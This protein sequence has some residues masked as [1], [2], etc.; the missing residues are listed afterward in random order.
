[1]TKLNSK[2]IFICATEQ[3]GDNIGY[4][5]IKKLKKIF[6][7]CTFDGVGGN[8]M[9]LYLDHQYFSIKDFKSIGIFEIIFS[10]K[11]YINMISYL[12]KMIIAK[13]YDL[14]ITI[15]SPDFNYPLIKKI[16]NKKFKKNTLHIVA[17]TVWAWRKYRAKKFAKIFNE[18]FIL[19]DFERSYFLKYGLNATLIGHPIYYINKIKNDNKKSNIAFL[20]GS[21]THE[22]DTLM[23]FFQIAYQYL[24]KEKIALDIFIPTLPHLEKKIKEYTKHWKLRIIITSN[25]NEI[26]KFF[27]DSKF[28]LVCSGTASLE[29]AKRNIPQ[30]VIYKLNLFTE[31]ILKFI[32]KIR[33]ANIINIIE[34]K[35]IIPE[36]TNSNLTKNNFLSE[37]SQLISNSHLN[38]NQIENINKTLPKI[39]SERPPYDIAVEKISEYL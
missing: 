23:P 25:H 12:S 17:P 29:I 11:K 28:A 27:L 18:I 21:R 19:F 20:P 30:L 36:L 4:N 10:I 7:N 24:I 9:S 2:K 32:T 16:R 26:E 37:F 1:M 3:S 8:N 5:I 13:D 34:N 15:D 6:P 39:H 22:I 31:I 35:M 38:R 14:I 33:Y